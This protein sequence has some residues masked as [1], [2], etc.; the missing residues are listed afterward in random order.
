[1]IITCPECSTKFKLDSDRIPDG[2][3]K[4]R[5]ARCKHVF[6]AEKPLEEEF[7]PAEGIPE[8]TT[9]AEDEFNYDK[10]QEL[11]SN[12]TSE[13]SFSFSSAGDTEEN[14]SFSEETEEPVS[15]IEKI[16][17]AARDE[18]AASEQVTDKDFTD[19]KQATPEA[20]AEPEFPPQTA[21]VK[22]SGA[23]SSIIR[24]LL[25]LILGI[26][27]VGGVFVYINGTD[28]LNQTI[29]QFF[30][31][32][33]NRPVQTG[34][35]TLEQLEGKFI[36]NEHD[37]EF[38]LIRGK[39]VNGFSEARAVIQVKGVIFDQNGKPLLQK[40]VF[41]GNP[42]DDEKIQSLSFQELEKMMGNQFGN[43]LSNMN[44]ASQQAIP[45]DI[46]FKDLP[47]NLSEF[48]VIVTSSKPATE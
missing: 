45:F 34:Q 41:C 43:E 42:I 5:C 32:Q 19:E 25:L 20:P 4:V 38:F 46:V 40:T 27:I 22:K 1:M 2:G 23:A 3:A 29:Q 21:P 15:T 13:E 37:G 35:I 30:G 12:T 10:F 24:I 39:A 18:E 28:Q 47:K 36:Q 14:F 48:S 31:Q 7:F 17:T 26:L 6:L 33:N 9:A 11:D 16:F 8:E 44:V